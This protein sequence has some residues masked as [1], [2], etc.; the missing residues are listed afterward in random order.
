MSEL[1]IFGVALILPIAAGVYLA[2]LVKE[3]G[4]NGMLPKKKYQWPTTLERE[5]L[6]KVT[7]H[8]EFCRMEKQT[9]SL[10]EDNSFIALR[11]HQI[12]LES[13][14]KSLDSVDLMSAVV[15]EKHED[16]FS[17]A[18]SNLRTIKE[19]LM[20]NR[21]NSRVLEMA[22]NTDSMLRKL[23]LNAH[24]TLADIERSTTS[25]LVS[26]TLHSMG[27]RIK[28]RGDTLV[29]SL[30]ETSIKAR[31]LSGGS[32]SLDTTS[33]NG[34][35]CHRE[36]ARFENELKENGVMLRRL[37]TSQAK[38]QESVLLRDPLP[39][40]FSS[41]KPVAGANSATWCPCSRK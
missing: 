3:L 28:A 29:G 9:L 20:D 32:I 21:P 31:V 25:E 8:K 36:V 22:S 6:L 4:T 33:F 37:M 24:T 11:N 18:K 13:M 19:A 7:Y 35:G 23:T 40:E 34:L 2:N 5:E 41:I 1:S 12:H 39:S 30:G 10:P 38:R 14:L 27:Y 26:D 16:M 15:Q 17:K